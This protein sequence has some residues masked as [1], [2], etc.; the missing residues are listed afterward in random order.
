MKGA[1]KVSKRISKKSL[2]PKPST[3]YIGPSLPGLAQYTVFRNGQW[4]AHVKTMIEGND[5]IAQLIVPVSRLQT[6]RGDMQMT[7][8]ILNF[9]AKQL[10]KG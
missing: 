4:P 3:V 5:T 10:L 6:A 8:H 7:G 9:Y 2:V 1:R